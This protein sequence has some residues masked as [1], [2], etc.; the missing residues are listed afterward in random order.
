[1]RSMKKTNEGGHL[2]KT[3]FKFQK[4]QFE[5]W[6]L[7]LKLSFFRRWIR[8]ASCWQ[9]IRFSGVVG[10]RARFFFAVDQSCAGE[11]HH[12]TRA[13]N[14]FFNALVVDE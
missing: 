4:S 3:N 1:M 10:V 12:I 2:K 6:S 11:R 14:T 5:V 8:I 9:R 7:K 13:Q